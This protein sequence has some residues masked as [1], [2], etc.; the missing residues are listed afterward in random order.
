MYSIIKDK[1][2][3]CGYCAFVCPFDCIVHHVDEKYYEIDQSKCKTCGQCYPACITKAIEKSADQKIVDTI[4]INDDCK[5][6]TL[7]AR[8]CPV[9]AISGEL[10]QKFVIDQDKCIKCGLCYTV[11]RLKGVDITYKD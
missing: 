11:C 3:D 8:N 10:K 2:A 9:G 7:C 6:C 5:G 4:I 1:C